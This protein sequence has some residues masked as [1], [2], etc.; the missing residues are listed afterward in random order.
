MI[1]NR[2][3]AKHTK[4]VSKSTSLSIIKLLVAVVLLI[5]MDAGNIIARTISPIRNGKTLLRVIEPKN[6]ALQALKPASAPADLSII[7][8][9]NILAA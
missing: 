1:A 6:G 5:P 4:R 7:D 3:M 9:L 2:P 8:Y